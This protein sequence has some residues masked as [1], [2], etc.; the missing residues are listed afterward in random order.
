MT[1]QDA[2]QPLTLE[3]FKGR[4]K[5][6]KSVVDTRLVSGKHHLFLPAG[7]VTVVAGSPGEGKTSLMLNLLRNLLRSEPDKKFYFFS[8]EESDIFLALKLLMIGSNV[9][10]AEDNLEA[11]G[12]L[13][14]AVDEFGSWI[15]EGRLHFGDH[16]L[17]LIR[18]R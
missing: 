10:L 2:S 4:I 11:N 3:H 13:A 12:E 6:L 15:G 17:D 8:Y 7:G 18:A 1:K 16:G 14:Y 5:R 9:V